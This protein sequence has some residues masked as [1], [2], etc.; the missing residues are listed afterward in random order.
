[1][2]Q[3]DLS[4]VDEAAE[5]IG[6]GPEKIIPLLQAIQTHYR[7]LPAEA[8][9]KLCEVTEI[10]RSQLTGVSTFYTQFRHKPAGEHRIKVCIGTACHVKGANRIYDSYLDDLGI[11]KGEDTDAD[12][13]FTVEKV[14][15]LGCCTLA[16]A[17][18]IDEVT[19][20]HL[21]PDTTSRSVRDFLELQKR[22]AEGKFPGV[23]ADQA[24][25]EIRISLDTCCMARGS[26]LVRDALEKAVAETRIPAVVKGVGC[27]GISAMEP[28]VE[29]C[30]QGRPPALYANVEPAD[31]RDI[32]L[33]HF[34]PKDFFGRVEA[35]A[36]RVLGALVEE[37]GWTRTHRFTVDVHDGPFR[38]FT[39]RQ[40]R[41][42]TEYCGQSRPLDLQEYLKFEGFGALERSLEMGPEKTI[43]AIE[44]SGLRGR[45][46]GGFPS[47]TKWRHV[48]GAAGDKKYVV[49]NCDE[50]DPGAFMDRMLLE[51]QPYRVI[52]GAAIAAQAVGADEVIFDVRAEY[53]LAVGRVLEA[54]Q[55]A[56]DAGYIGPGA[57][58]GQLNVDMQ[59]M[60]GAGAFVCGEET[61]LLA[62]IEGHRG[63]PRL[64]PP[65]PSRQGLWGKPTLVNNTET[66]SCVPWVL[67]NGPEAFASMGTANS[68]G[69]KVFALAGKIHRGGLIEV[70]MG[71]TIRQ[72][73]D[74]VGGGVPD[75]KAFKAVQIGGPSGGCIPASLADTP[76]DY[77]A[78][79]EL[80][81]MMGSGGL[82]VLDED[83]CMVEIA[84]YFLE[85]T[86]DQSCGKCTFCRVGTRRMLELLT[87]LTEGEGRPEHLDALEELCHQ[88]AA[89]SLCGLGKTAPNPVLTT[90]RFFREEYEAHVQG[91]CPAGDCAALIHYRITD[92]CIGCT[93]CAQ[94]C[95]A[96]AIAMQPYQKHE[97]DDEKCVR[98]GGCRDICPVAA[99]RVE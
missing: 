86:Q 72:V 51:S 42:A 6:R 4:Y 59:V 92:D 21:T 60:E 80:G 23:P 29:I 13:L 35:L 85:F 17:V 81:A 32:I 55:T 36:D 37:D 9:E 93:K 22:R 91:R 14:A 96:D 40:V 82:V 99:V 83:D 18:M 70:P 63:M 54:I 1:M 20:G 61:A 15:C 24:V 64:R 48:R 62:S 49:V 78:L 57:M 34:Q 30:V 74:E 71:T 8:L 90:L 77:E 39:G 79:T 26:H 97:I 28:L 41:V 47:A 89:G 94:V 98:C 5:R 27:M 7:Y 46:G 50:G 43:D 3:T 73:V 56:R 38:D 11:P 65:Y 25:G 84:R 88:V 67:R 87:T 52:E 75:G 31:A 2:T 76:I 45:G 44:A 10:S 16:P 69:T 58:A 12:G 95:P 68:K 53:P 19:Y 66:L 33:R